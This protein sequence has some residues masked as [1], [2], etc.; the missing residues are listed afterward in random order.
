MKKIIAYKGY[1]NEFVEKLTFDEQQKLRKIL[2]L[3]KTEDRIPRHFVKYIRDGVYELRMPK[4][5]T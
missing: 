4:Y 3:L 1:F 5:R 2:G